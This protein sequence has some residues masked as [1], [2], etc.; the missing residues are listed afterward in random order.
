MIMQIY[1]IETSEDGKELT[2]H[3]FDDFPCAFYDEKFS[4]FI[5]GEVPWHWHDEVELVFVVEGSSKVESLRNSIILNKGDAVFI[6]SGCLHK[7]TNF[8]EQDC[9]ILNFVL[10]PV[11]IGGSK[12]SRVYKNYVFPIVNNTQIT[13]YKFVSGLSWHQQAIDEL[14]KGF[15]SC[16]NEEM[17]DE[18]VLQIHLMT[19]WNIFYENEPKVIGENPVSSSS[20][21]R[22]HCF[23]SYI[24]AHYRENISVAAISDAA[25]ISESECYR[26]FKKTLK[27]T[28]NQYLSEYRLQKAANL[29]FETDKQ[30]TEIAHHVGFNCPAYFTKKFRLA[31]GKTPKQFRLKIVSKKILKNI[32]Q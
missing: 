30:V 18:L 21:R 7:L 6:N 13:L 23:L 1:N 14:K 31:Y 17:N 4:Q 16:Q 27:S 15:A 8:G 25:N 10:N 22:V 5:G 26:I 11:V 3:G 28:P 19:F 9:H 24:H 32:P 29:L 20:E 2:S 12:H